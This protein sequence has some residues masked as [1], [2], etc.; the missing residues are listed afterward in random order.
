MSFSSSSWCTRSSRLSSKPSYAL[1][2][3]SHGFYGAPVRRQGLRS[4]AAFA[5]LQ[6]TAALD[7]PSISATSLPAMPDRTKGDG[8]RLQGGVVWLQDPPASSRATRRADSA[9]G[10]A[11]GVWG[12]P[13]CA[14]RATG[15]TALLDHIDGH[16]LL[17]VRVARHR[18]L[19]NW[20]DLVQLF[21]RI[22]LP[23]AFLWN[24]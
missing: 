9:S 21:V 22:P 23:L 14:S 2:S 4:S 11:S 12:S 17:L 13:A 5:Q 10:T 3:E 19:P 16:A 6:T 20:T 15:F 18:E 7:T 1:S 8:L 24:Q